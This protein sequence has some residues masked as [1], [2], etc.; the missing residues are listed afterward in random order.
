MVGAWLVHGWCLGKHLTTHQTHLAGPKDAHFRGLS[1]SQ[2]QDSERVQN[3]NART[4]KQVSLLRLVSLLIY[5]FFIRE[6]GL[7]CVALS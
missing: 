7:T 5:I 3:N 6:S 2:K 4:T 1:L